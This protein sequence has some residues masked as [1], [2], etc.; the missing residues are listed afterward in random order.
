MS[1]DRI[2]FDR[3]SAR[4]EAIDF[5]KGMRLGKEHLLDFALAYKLA[6]KIPFLG[7]ETSI[8]YIII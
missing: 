2:Y 5:E 4:E 3:A 1:S 6:I 7:T 8:T